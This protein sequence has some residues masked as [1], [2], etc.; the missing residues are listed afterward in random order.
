MRME[1]I[2]SWA[3]MAVIGALVFAFV[4]HFWWLILI[5]LALF[6]ARVMYLRHKMKKAA[7]D[8]YR[9]VEELAE[10]SSVETVDYLKPGDVIDAE[11]VEVKEERI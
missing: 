9:Q 3:V 10:E 11:Y 6:A 5:V 1:E 7:D 2:V 8:F 4:W